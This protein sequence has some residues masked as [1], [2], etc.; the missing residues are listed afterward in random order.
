MS[1]PINLVK[2]PWLEK[3]YGPGEGR[4]HDHSVKWI[5]CH[6]AF[7]TCIN[8]QFGAALNLGQTTLFLQGQKLMQRPTGQSPEKGLKATQP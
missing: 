8:T 1:G 7:E 2:S 6:T 5:Q 4:H 3:S